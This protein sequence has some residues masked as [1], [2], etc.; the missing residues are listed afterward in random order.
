VARVSVNPCR[1]Q[2]YESLLRQNTES[3]LN[4]NERQEIEYLRA[5]MDLLVYR[6]SFAMVLLKW[7]GFELSS[8]LSSPDNAT[9]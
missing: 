2:R 5:E 4:D 9:T 6:K 8:L 1:W 7:R 3:V